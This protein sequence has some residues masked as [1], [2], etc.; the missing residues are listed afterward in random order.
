MLVITLILACFLSGCNNPGEETLS[1]FSNRDTYYYASTIFEYYEEGYYSAIQNVIDYKGCY[2]AIVNSIS[3]DLSGSVNR[4][5]CID[6]NGNQISRIDLPDDINIYVTS[7]IENDEL[8]YVTFSNK[9]EKINI[10]TGEITY[11]QDYD[12]DL[13][14]ATFIDD[15]YI[16][17][18]I[19]KVDK[20][21]NNGSLISTI[22]NDDWAFFNGYRTFYAAND[23][24]YLLSDDGFSWKYYELDFDKGTQKLIYDPQIDNTYISNCSS[25]YLFNDTGEYMLDFDNECIYTLSKWS[26][27][28]LQPPRY[29]YVDP[30]FI[31]ID[32]STFLTIYNY[33]N[34]ISELLIYTYD[35]SKD[36]SGRTTLTVGG[37]NCNYDLALKWAIYDY[38]TSQSEYRAYIEDYTEEFGWETISEGAQQQ[39]TLIKYFNDGNAPDIFYGNQ[40][41]YYGFYESGMTID[42]LQ[43]ADDQ[44]IDRLNEVTPN[45]KDL[46]IDDSGSCYRIFSSYQ[47]EGYISSTDLVDSN[48]MSIPELLDISNNT[49]ITFITN[50]NANDLALNAILFTNGLEE[51][52]YRSILQYSID[53]G[54]QFADGASLPQ[55]DNTWVD[56]YLL[57]DTNIYSII[58]LDDIEKGTGANFEFLGYPSLYNTSHLIIPFGQVA[59]SSS[60]VYPDECC[61]LLSYLLDDNVQNLNNLS[62][63]IPVNDEIMHKMVDYS[64]DHSIIPDSDYYYRTY[65]CQDEINEETAEDFYKMIEAVDTVQYFDWGLADIID[66][67]VNSYF[68]QNKPVDE[69]A[70]SLYSR[71][72]LYLS[73]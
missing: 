67:E 10:N 30:Q 65:L 44:L 37:F 35:P 46:M 72:E 14:G 23:K 49:G 62:C 6:G 45:I 27:I 19:G 54:V 52:D 38:N 68:I 51:E 3:E 17:L 69:I 9:V 57:W 61:K 41:D 24:Y 16:V 21:D 59:V 15:G 13:C 50:R 33:D 63:Y 64:L 7:D 36:N 42:I 73:E 40:F 47:I 34:G 18:S 55:L 2:Y 1:E 71:I 5:I 39:A 26:D 58:R 28:D 53:K 25:E 48:D 31:G 20:Y 8:I 4:L 43:Y 29:T 70:Q 60:T 12:L 11:S 56:E 22:N 32:E 66:D